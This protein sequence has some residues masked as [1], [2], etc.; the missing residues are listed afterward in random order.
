MYLSIREKYVALLPPPKKKDETPN[1]DLKR[2]GGKG[3]V[4][5]IR[6]RS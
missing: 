2:G 3:A 4:V 6:K 5:H 1:E